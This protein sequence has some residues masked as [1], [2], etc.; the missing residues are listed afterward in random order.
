VAT[1][2]Q[3]GGLEASFLFNCT[4][5]NATITDFIPLELYRVYSGGAG[6]VHPP[7]HMLDL[8]SEPRA[9]PDLT[10]PKS[11]KP[12]SRDLQGSGPI[13]EAQENFPLSDVVEAVMLSFIAG[14]FRHRCRKLHFVKLIAG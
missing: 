12:C 10:Q 7:H 11:F 8:S 5:G 6:T 1:S 3:S 9:A 4:T 13:E 14:R 2:R